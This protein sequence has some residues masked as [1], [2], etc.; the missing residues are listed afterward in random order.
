LIGGGIEEPVQV[1]QKLE[2]LLASDPLCWEFGERIMVVSEDRVEPDGGES[3]LDKMVWLDGA[4]HI[5]VVPEYCHPFCVPKEAGLKERA[6]W[7]I[8]FGLVGELEAAKVVGCPLVVGQKSG[9]EFRIKGCR[10]EDIRSADDLA[11]CC[12]AGISEVAA[13]GWRLVGK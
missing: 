7:A 5:R 11:G 1:A 10:E 2:G 4:F 12:S 9:Q 6:D 13:D 3:R 8:G